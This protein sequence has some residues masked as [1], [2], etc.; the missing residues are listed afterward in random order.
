M[1]SELQD[2]FA[3]GAADLFPTAGQPVTLT[4]IARTGSAAEQLSLPAVISPT[5]VAWE[6]TSPSGH[7]VT[8][9]STA[10]IRRADCPRRP[11][12]GDRIQLQDGSVFEIVRSTGW[13]LGSTWHL[14][15]TLIRA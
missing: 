11:S 2:I 12:P 13:S 5:E 15:L 14:D 10:V 3:Q 9:D 8:C 4:R 6:L 1:S 7:T